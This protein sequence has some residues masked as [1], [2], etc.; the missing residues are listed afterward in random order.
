[1]SASVQI[2]CDSCL[3]HILKQGPSLHLTMK[4][5]SSLLSRLPLDRKFHKQPD[6]SLVSGVNFFTILINSSFEVNSIPSG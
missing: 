3:A 4:C 5:S 6:A 2:I 1:M